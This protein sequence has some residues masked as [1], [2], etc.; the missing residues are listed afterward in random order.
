MVGWDNGIAGA[1]S[2]AGRGVVA[3]YPHP[4]FYP[5][6]FR[7]TCAF[8][9]HASCMK[10]ERQSEG[11]TR[12][13]GGKRR[14]RGGGGC[15]ILSRGYSFCFFLPI[16]SDAQYFSERYKVFIQTIVALSRLTFS[17]YGL[18]QPGFSP[19]LIVSTIHYYCTYIGSSLGSPSRLHEGR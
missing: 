13:G 19:P 15:A 18:F 11:H 4:S 8:S 3:G 9:R 14:A 1:E 7:P 6:Q 17:T 12:P 5:H 10:A 16:E 2:P